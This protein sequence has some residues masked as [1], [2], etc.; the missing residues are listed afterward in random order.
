MDERNIVHITFRQRPNLAPMI[1]IF[2]V[3]GTTTSVSFV[4][5]TL[6]SYI[7]NNLYDYINNQWDD[8]E[9]KIVVALLTDQSNTDVRN[10]V[11]GVVPIT[12]G[13][14]KKDSVYFNVLWQM[15]EK[16]STPSLK[17]LQGHVMRLGFKTGALVGHVYRDFENLLQTIYESDCRVYTYSS[18]SV[19][20]Q[21][22]LFEHSI[23]GNLSKYFKGH[24][25]SGIGKKDDPESYKNI[26]R[27]LKC[28]PESI[29]YFTDSYEEAD[30]AAEAGCRTFVICR[31][32]GLTEPKY[33][34][35]RHWTFKTFSQ[36][37]FTN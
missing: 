32:D 9:F 13:N 22:L 17:L 7:R 8:E 29:G 19:E 25:D 4:R 33:S 16:R 30:A 12:E 26:A 10:N 6:F 20:A 5:D 27:K 24:F 34:E 1:L 36:V 18:G 15:N 23:Y 11:K 3:E 14:N 31:T 2:D 37:L 35:S 21:E 28:K